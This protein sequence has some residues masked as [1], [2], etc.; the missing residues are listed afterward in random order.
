L[1][2]LVEHSSQQS[3]A[4]NH[5]S[6]SRN[7]ES[8]RTDPATILAGR[9]S[10]Y[11][12]MADWVRR[13]AP[14]RLPALILGE[15]GSG[16]EGVAHAIHELGPNARG[17]F[18]AVNC[19]AVSESLLEAE[20]FGVIRGAFTGADRD[21]EGLLRT[22][23]GGTLFLDEVGD[24]PLSMQSKLLRA[25]DNRR[26]RAVGGSIET[27]LDFRVVSATHRNL[28]QRVLEGCFRE[29]FMHRIA[30]VEI[31][32]PALRE[33]VGDLPLIVEA[34]APRLAAETGCSAIRLGTDAWEAL[35]RHTWPGNV[36]QLHAVLAR[37][38]L[39][40]NGG[41]IEARHL[42][43]GVE[44]A[45]RESY[46][47]QMMIEQAL[48]ESNGVVSG[49]AERIGWTR[50]KLT[51]RMRVL[52]IRLGNGDQRCGVSGTTSSNSSTFQ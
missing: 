43:D 25:I 15:T 28:P 29:D 1:T 10:A 5:A 4:S 14:S 37:A 7:E 18:V 47:E 45:G 13:I 34:L 39:R 31:R 11:S 23:S 46:L 17:P 50:Q 36:R 42:D 21:R 52:D 9:S 40:A 24:M 41:L 20:L 32:V 48:I 27:A 51:R 33:R 16:K 22:A 3:A 44:V 35:A 19:A 12:A 38:L 6:E 2:R 26:S 49:A 8:G 30:V